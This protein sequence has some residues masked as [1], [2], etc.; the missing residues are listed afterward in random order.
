M[1][2]LN[3]KNK[4]LELD[5]F[6]S[7]QIKKKCFIICASPL[8]EN[9]I[10]R[11]GLD[12]LKNYFNVYLIDALKC[13]QKSKINYIQCKSENFNII[14][15]KNFHEL[16]REV[17]THKPTFLI[18]RVGKSEYTLIIQSICREERLSYVFDQVSQ[19][20]AKNDDYLI[21]GKILKLLINKYSIKLINL[22]KKKFIRPDIVLLG[23]SN[24]NYWI[25]LSKKIIQTSD[26]S[27]LKYKKL[28]NLKKRIHSE[29]YILFLDDCLADSFDFKLGFK[30][31][32]NN[33]KKYL[34]EL[35]DFFSFLE[36]KFNMDVIIAGHP[37]GIQ[38]NNYKKIFNGRSL[39][40]NK[41]AEL[42]KDCFFA[43]THYSKS[44][45]FPILF[46]KPIIQLHLE[47]FNNYKNILKEMS[48][49]KKI[50]G[51]STIN[52]NND[53]TNLINSTT[54]K[55][56]NSSYEFFIKKYISNIKFNIKN[57]YEPLIE[58]FIK[59][60]KHEYY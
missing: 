57:S 6:N 16:S 27:F 38:I 47:D 3:S 43:L 46:K 25:S 53:Y 36:Q 23:G 48:L 50:L 9:I 21:S 4:N 15:I 33:N 18:D 40:F 22:F 20:P 37:N 11:I 56:N 55:I 2:K 52:I 7:E 30:K 49:R 5:D 24:K 26:D 28:V 51:I 41:T 14:D 32:I 8:T 1:S 34:N 42:S 44:I 45:Q 60:Q 39:Y 31:I 29:N 35:N 10:S 17:K 58:Y 12:Y 13:I 19:T 54:L 59:K